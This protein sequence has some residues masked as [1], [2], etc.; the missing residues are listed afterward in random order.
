MVLLM[1]EGR[2]RKDNEVINKLRS[3][4]LRILAH[5]VALFPLVV[6]IWDYWTGAFLVDPV[7]EITTRTGRTA[8]VLLIS[9]LA[10]TPIHAIFGFRQVLRIRRALGLY[11]FLYAGL[12]FLTFAG[13]DYAFDLKLLGPA[14]F[15]QR[16]VLPGAAAFLILLLLAA[17]STRRWQERLG[18]KWKW[19]HRLSYLAGV[20]VIVHF[21][22]LTKDSRK[23]LQYGAIIALLLILRI[24]GI[25]RPMG[26]VR[27][28]IKSR[29][30]EQ[31]GQASDL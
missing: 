3:D 13:W 30:R 2:A 22:W 25:K 20:L 29:E 27:R 21:L 9:S 7:R 11:A 18:K 15:G 4:W 23:P 5:V 28:W 24:P 19:L 26:S 14:I 17:T 16:F 12:H 8:L 6:I 31:H 1:P 10:C